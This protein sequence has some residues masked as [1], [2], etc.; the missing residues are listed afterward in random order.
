MDET[1]EQP[2][3]Q[4]EI[5]DKE[6]DRVR[7]L[8]GIAFDC[9]SE[10]V[11]DDKSI[12]RDILGIVFSP[13]LMVGLVQIGLYN[14]FFDFLGDLGNAVCRFVTGHMFL[15]GLLFALLFVASV[16]NLV[17]TLVFHGKLKLKK[18]LDEDVAVSVA[19]IKRF[20]K[21]HVIK[22]ILSLVFGL[23]MAAVGSVLVYFVVAALAAPR[24]LSTG[25]I[26]V[27]FGVVGLLCVI[28]IVSVI[29]GIKQFSSQCDELVEVLEV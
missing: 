10:F 26:A 8:K 17:L 18:I 23:M 25:N 11:K 19:R 12:V 24:E 14:L 28:A 20:K 2:I 9:K 7:K 1:R 3:E 16:V 4:V 29:I 15:I 13:I 21:N 22:E 6:N 27:I 5:I